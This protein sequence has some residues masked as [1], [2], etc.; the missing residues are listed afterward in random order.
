MNQA[1]KPMTTATLKKQLREAIAAHNRGG[2]ISF[3][4]NWNALHKLGNNTTRSICRQ[5]AY[6]KCG[7]DKDKITMKDLVEWSK[8]MLP[9]GVGYKNQDI[10]DD[11]KPYVK[12]LD[13]LALK[14]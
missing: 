3:N 6:G 10:D 2:D 11:I 7:D 14:G 13:E 12:L 5:A 4:E 1:T 9:V 8:G